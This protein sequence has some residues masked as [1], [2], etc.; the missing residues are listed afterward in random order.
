MKKDALLRLN[1][2]FI[3]GKGATAIT[4]SFYTNSLHVY[5]RSYVLATN[6]NVWGVAPKPHISYVSRSKQISL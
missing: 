3:I 2:N 5:K 6:Y 1:S 4:V